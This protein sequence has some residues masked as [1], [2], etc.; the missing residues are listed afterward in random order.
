MHSVCGEM[1]VCY[2]SDEVLADA[3]K[4]WE[5]PMKNGWIEG[6][7]EPSR[8]VFIRGAREAHVAP[9]IDVMTPGANAKSNTQT[10]IEEW[11]K[12]RLRQ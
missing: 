7:G 11:Y 4:E 9:I 3:I 8:V 5:G 2:G 10:A 6:G 1:F 12:A